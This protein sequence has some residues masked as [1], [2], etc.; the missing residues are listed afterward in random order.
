MMKTERTM[1][2]D[3]YAPV[4]AVA[5][6]ISD[7][8]EDIV[9]L[10]VNEVFKKHGPA[11]AE[12]R[13]TVKSLQRQED[14]RDW[15]FQLLNEPYPEPTPFGVRSPLLKAKDDRDEVETAKDLETYYTLYSVGRREGFKAGVALMAKYM[16]PGADPQEL[17]SVIRALTDPEHAEALLAALEG[18]EP[19]GTGEGAPLLAAV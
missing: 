15:R 1:Y 13:E 14:N 17:L 12:L 8:D 5:P 7:R 16:A 4:L 6:R 10:V 19:K 2:H 3:P 9:D 18:A 11:L